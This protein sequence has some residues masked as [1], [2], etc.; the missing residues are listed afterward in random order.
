[1]ARWGKLVSGFIALTL[2]AAVYTI[3]TSSLRAQFAIPL[4]LAGLFAVGTYLLLSKLKAL[5]Q[6]TEF[7]P[8]I[9]AVAS[10][11]MVPRS[12]YANIRFSMLD[13]TWP[14]STTVD[15]YIMS[16]ALLGVAVY[17]LHST[18]ILREYLSY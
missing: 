15:P 18:G 4:A 14:G 7:I 1:M 9:V 17:F 5:N 16:V 11:F 6:T 8:F 10:F 3:W 13:F 2:F 12:L